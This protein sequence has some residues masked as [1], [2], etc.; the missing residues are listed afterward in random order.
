M[1]KK[2]K[3]EMGRR[4][5]FLTMAAAG[6]AL[7]FLRELFK[8]PKIAFRRLKVSLHPAQFYRKIDAGRPGGQG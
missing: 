7:P 1:T 8:S 6:M 2:E 4:K 3:A 5:F